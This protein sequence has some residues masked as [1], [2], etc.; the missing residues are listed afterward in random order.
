M[1]RIVCCCQVKYKDGEE[2]DLWLGIERV[3]LMIQPGEQL[4]PPDA[5][6]LRELAQCYA[7][8]AQLLQQQLAQQQGSR[9]DSMDVDGS[10]GEDEVSSRQ[11][12]LKAGLPA[13]HARMY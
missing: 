11:C 7:E 9:S 1:R 4:Q 12:W 6:T 3:R 8:R 13:G 10:D 2:E 5:A